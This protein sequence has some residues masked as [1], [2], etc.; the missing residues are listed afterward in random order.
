MKNRI[1]FLIVF[2]LIFVI[3][4]NI[5]AITTFDVRRKSVKIYD[6]LNLNEII[7]SDKENLDYASSNTE[8]ASVNSDG[9]VTTHCQG[10]AVITVSDGYTTDLL[11][12]SSGYYTGIDVS[13]ANGNVDWKKVKDYGIDFAMIRAGFGW[14]DE[15]DIAAGQAFEAQ[16]DTQFLNNLKGVSDND[17]PFGVYHVSYAKTMEQAEK[18][19]DYLLEIVN[20]YGSQYKD[21]ITLPIAYDVEVDTLQSVGRAE[22]TNIAIKFC[23]KIYE[24]GYIPIIYSYKNFLI[25]YL[26][27]DKINAMAYNIWYA[28]YGIEDENSVDYSSKITIG[29]TNITPFMWQYSRKGNIVGA[30]TSSGTVDLNIMYMKDRVKIDVIQDENI[31]DIIGVDK[32]ESIEKYPEISKDGY[33][34]SEFRDDSGKIVDDNYKFNSDS[35]IYASF[36]RINITDITLNIHEIKLNTLTPAQNYILKIDSYLP[37]NAIIENGDIVFKTDNPNVAIVDDNGKISFVGKG[38]CNITAYLKDNNE[39]L[40][41]CNV[42]LNPEIVKGDIN[43]DGYI[44]STD[45]AIVLDRFKNKDASQRDYELGDMNE[46]KFLDSTDAAMILDIFKN[47]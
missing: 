24:A 32:G 14:Y 31:V 16:V 20:N 10:Q 5:Y 6:K 29:N 3:S 35:R 45:A 19:A 41:V 22:L 25:N 7:T 17:I 27:V 18:E 8:V 28:D 39:I 9:I 37:N 44:N 2:T 42:E 13:Y 23:T 4:S 34:L 30:N 26:D 15:A 46:D 1:F 47:K 40:D 36:D 33:I 21:K 38:K 43:E 12:L 11:I